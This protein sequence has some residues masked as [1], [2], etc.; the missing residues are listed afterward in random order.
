MAKRWRNRYRI[1]KAVASPTGQLPEALTLSCG[2][3]GARKSWPA[4]EAGEFTDHCMS[5]STREEAAEYSR[6]KYQFARV[7]TLGPSMGDYDMARPERG[8]EGWG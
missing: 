6:S 5:Y 7:E 4:D 8:R 2:I 3:C 1:K